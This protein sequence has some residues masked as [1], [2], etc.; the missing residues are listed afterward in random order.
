MVNRLLSASFSVASEALRGGTE[1][2]TCEVAASPNQHRSVVANLGF[3][4][5]SS[6]FLQ[7]CDTEASSLS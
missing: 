1:H 2:I 3:E 6:Q 7:V 4:I 5:E